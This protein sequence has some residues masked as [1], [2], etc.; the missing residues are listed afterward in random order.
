MAIADFGGPALLDLAIGIPGDEVGTAKDAGSV[1]VRYSGQPT[2][3]TQRWTQ[4]VQGVPDNAEPGDQLGLALYGGDFDN[5][6]HG[7]LAIGIPFEDISGLAD[8]GAFTVLYSTSV[9]GLVGAGSDLWFQDSP[10]VKGIS[11]A[12]DR[13]GTSMP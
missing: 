3:P 13:F 5:S 11:E 2:S 12:G 7:D 9:G 10:D 1:I 4:N 6:H 8:A